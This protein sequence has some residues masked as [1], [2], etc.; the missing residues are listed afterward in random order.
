VVGSRSAN[1][2]GES[3]SKENGFN[4]SNP[5]NKRL[6][7]LTDISIAFLS[8]LFF[9]FQFLLQRKPL[10]FL[11]NCISVLLGSHTWIGYALPQ[12]DLPP[13]RNGI[14][15]ANGIPVKVKQPLTEESLQMMDQWYA[16]DYDPVDELKLIRKLYRRLG[17]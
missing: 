6:K 10:S 1:E 14:M 15:A 4:L 2:A 3:L 8:L 12:K 13:L 17:G 7:R 16:R 5:Y 9:P 11:K